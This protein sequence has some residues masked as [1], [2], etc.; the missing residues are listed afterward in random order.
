MQDHERNPE[1][2]RRLEEDDPLDHIQ[3]DE[4][5]EDVEDAWEE[6]DVDSGEAPSG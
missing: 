1:V 2:T 6:T 5:D 3:P 4:E